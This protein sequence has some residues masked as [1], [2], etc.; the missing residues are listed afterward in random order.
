M[1]HAITTRNLL[2][3]HE[4]RAEHWA[5]EAEHANSKIEREYAE[6]QAMRNLNTASRYLEQLIAM[7]AF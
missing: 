3:Y 1:S 5:I 6:E 4:R 2:E 7:G